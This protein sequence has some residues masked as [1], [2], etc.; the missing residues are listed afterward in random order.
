MCLYLHTTSPCAIACFRGHIGES[1][2]VFCDVDSE[3]PLRFSGL[4]SHP[5]DKDKSIICQ[6]ICMKML[7]VNDL[8]FC[9]G[10]TGT[11]PAILVRTVITAWEMAQWL[12]AWTL[13][14]Q[15]LYKSWAVV[16]HTCKP[17]TEVEG[18]GLSYLLTGQPFYLKW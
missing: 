16:A 4:L 5:D 12:G 15:S 1:V 9:G 3:D 13:D 11:K 18:T 7:K 8:W 14:S 6:L 17:S 10:V 2:F